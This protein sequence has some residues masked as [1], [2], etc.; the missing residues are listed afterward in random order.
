MRGAT[1]RESQ[2]EEGESAFVSMTDMTVSVLF[3]VIIL[4]AFFATQVGRRDTVDLYL[5]EQAI[6]ERDRAQEERD[7]LKAELDQLLKR[8][9]ALETTLALTRARAVSLEVKLARA[10]W[11]I[12]RLHAELAEMR[13]RLED[14][15]EVYIAA[16]A[17]RRREVLNEIARALRAEFPDLEMEISAQG[18]ALRFRGDGLFRTNEAAIRDDRRPIVAALARKLDDIL[19]CYT[20]G[21]ASNFS[22]ACNP[23]FALVEAVQVEG[24]TD[25]DGGRENNV[26][27]SAQRGAE[28]YIAM[29]TDV[30]RLLD[31]RN[32]EGQPV[33]SLAGYGWERPV[34]ANDTRE[35][36]SQNRRI[37]LRIIMT[38]PRNASEIDRIRSVLQGAVDDAER[39][40]A[41]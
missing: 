2:A 17:M 34:V 13:K 36:K 29:T 23:S 32:L 18:E 39:G 10:Q 16:A 31:H 25:S 6:N 26:R 12:A 7:A 9:A 41:P 28:T 14:P 3:I 5:Y 20:T 35:H 19:P 22:K 11:Q 21:P 24:H 38:S 40:T 15:L 1:R 4:L 27:L 33:F 37:D 30:V 8:I